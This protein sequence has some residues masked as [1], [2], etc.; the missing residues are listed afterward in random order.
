MV[1]R[2]GLE[3]REW[4]AGNVWGVRSGA[5]MAAA[6][7]EAVVDQLFALP[8]DNE[9]GEIEHE[10]RKEETRRPV[11]KVHVLRDVGPELVKV[12][13]RGVERVELA[14]AVVILALAHEQVARVLFGLVNRRWGRQL[15]WRRRLPTDATVACPTG[16]A[17]AA[18]ARRG[19][20]RGGAAEAHERAR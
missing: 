16:G 3:E 8:V 1:G 4:R 11:H 9:V 13:Q 19:V 10:E 18:C 5:T 12:A 15:E 7:L 14:G 17:F 2:A 20:V 6:H